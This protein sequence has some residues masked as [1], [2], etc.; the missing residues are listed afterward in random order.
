M[1]QSLGNYMEEMEGN[2]LVYE[3]RDVDERVYRK[4]SDASVHADTKAGQCT[5]M[6]IVS[7]L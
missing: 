1:G 5:R 7:Y 2:Y 6:P 4:S 3:S